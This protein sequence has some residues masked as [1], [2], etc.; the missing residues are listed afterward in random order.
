MVCFISAQT[1]S[2]AGRWE[3]KELSPYR[4]GSCSVPGCPCRSRN[5]WVREQTPGFSL[6]H[7]ELMKE[8]S[9]R[10][11]ISWCRIFPNLKLFSLFYCTCWTIVLLNK[12]NLSGLRSAFV[13]HISKT[14]FLCDMIGDRLIPPHSPPPN[15]GLSVRMKCTGEPAEVHRDSGAPGLKLSSRYHS[16]CH[17]WV[18]RH[19]E[20]HPGKGKQPLQ[21][22]W[23][24]PYSAKENGAPAENDGQGL[25]DGAAFPLFI[26]YVKK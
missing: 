21:G 1:P 26:K 20:I 10:N 25:W 17:W 9:V 19:W 6:L 22:L 16:P 13:I 7:K 2:H 18:L 3:W 8:E 5:T 4:R 12:K 11:C 24:H 14:I 15:L 23:L